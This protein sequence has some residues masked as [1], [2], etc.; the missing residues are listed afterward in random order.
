MQWEWKCKALYIKIFWLVASRIYLM[1]FSSYR[2]SGG[3]IAT[4][5]TKQNKHEIIFFEKN[6]L[7][8]LEFTLP[9]D[10]KKVQVRTIAVILCCWCLPLILLFSLE[11]TV[12]TNL[13]DTCLSFPTKILHRNICNLHLVASVK[14][15]AVQ[16]SVHYQIIQHFFLELFSQVKEL[17]WNIE[18]SVLAVWCQD[19][20]SDDSTSSHLHDYGEWNLS[21]YSKS[22]N[23]PTDHL[24]M[25]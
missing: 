11:I 14:C 25:S 4:S 3:L 2:P 24:G 22:L 5:Q 23:S 12:Y 10:V 17:A 1:M 7:R 21:L 6:G 18:S 19:L 20:P 8:H 9:F 16:D 15:S 13:N